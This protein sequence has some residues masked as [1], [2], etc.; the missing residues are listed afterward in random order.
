MEDYLFYPDA[1][2]GHT[3]PVWLA[4]LDGHRYYI[5]EDNEQ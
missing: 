5:V 3:L 2:A 4:V 1:D